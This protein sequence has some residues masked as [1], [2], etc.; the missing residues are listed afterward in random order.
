MNADPNG[1]RAVVQ[2]GPTRLWDAVERGYATWEATGHPGWERLGVTVTESGQW[3]WIDQAGNEYRWDLH[4][5]RP[6]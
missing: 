6:A 1:H 2:G 4:T 5:G 3:V